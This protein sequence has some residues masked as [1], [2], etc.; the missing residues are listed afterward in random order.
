MGSESPSKT[1]LN[2][3]AAFNCLYQNK[4]RNAADMNSRKFHVHLES[5]Y[6]R[7]NVF[8]LKYTFCLLLYSGSPHVF[9]FF[10]LLH[11]SEQ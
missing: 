2:Y 1:P 9:F 7:R 6:S 4:A 8:Q 11:D 5:V 10:Y 3:L